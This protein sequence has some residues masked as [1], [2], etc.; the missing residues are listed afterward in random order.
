MIVLLIYSVGSNLNLVSMGEL[1][2]DPGQ[3]ELSKGL[4]ASIYSR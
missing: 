1:F 4:I 3:H 2:I